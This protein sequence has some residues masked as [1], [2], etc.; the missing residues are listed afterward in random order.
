[1]SKL[2]PRQWLYG[3]WWTAP[4]SGDPIPL[5]PQPPAPPQDEYGNAI[6][7]PDGY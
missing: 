7:L 2:D 3:K 5:D 6:G 1:M 4:D